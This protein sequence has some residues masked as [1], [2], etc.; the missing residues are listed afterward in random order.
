MVARQ[1]AIKISEH[2]KIPIGSDKFFNEIHPKLK[3]V[4]TVI[5]GV[6]I[7]GSCQGPKNISES[8]QS[9]LAAT[10]KMNALLQSGSVSVDPIVASVNAEA[11]TWCGK[12]ADVCDYG[13]LKE[14]EGPT[15]KHIA[16]VNK[17]VCTGCG[18]CAPICP[19]NAI[20]VAQYTD[21][22]IEAMIDGFMTDF[23]I[24]ER[25][26]ETDDTTDEGATHMKEYPQVWKEILAGIKDEKN[27]IP[28]IASNTGLSA[29]LVTWHLMTMNRYAIVVA[30]G[31]DEDQQYYYYKKKH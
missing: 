2:L 1:D 4:E 9:T 31:T 10:A 5:K 22:E 27:T 25:V 14:V 12:C 15:G 16:L 6:Y 26:K 20:E 17:G 18:I 11:C 8:V 29:D 3:P 13:A 7:G 21:H 23:E 24:K 28:E 30:D 19:I